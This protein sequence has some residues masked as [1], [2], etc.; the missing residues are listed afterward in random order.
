[1]YMIN[2][3]HS[4]QNLKPVEVVDCENGATLV[5]VA[6]EAKPFALSGAM[7]TNQVDVHYLIKTK[8]YPCNL[9]HFL[10]FGGGVS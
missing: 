3:N 1:M 4:V 8:I 2:S 9:K 10:F 7:I 5:L 6:Q